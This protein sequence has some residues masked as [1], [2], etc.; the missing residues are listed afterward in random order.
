CNVCQYRWRDEA[1]VPVLLTAVK[2]RSTVEK[3]YQAI[4]MMSADD[5]AEIRTVLRDVAITLDQRLHE[6]F[7]KFRGDI[8]EGE[9]V[10]RCG[11]RLAGVEPT[12]KRNP[13]GGNSQVRGRVNNRRIFA[14]ELEHDRCQVLCRSRHDDLRYR[15]SA[16]EEDVIPLLFQQRGGLGDRAEHNGKRLAVEVF[17]KGARDRFAGRRRNF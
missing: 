5:P 17:R 3:L 12:T 11:A 4:E 9:N 16:S 6:A 13:A 2:N 14:A 10:V 15:G 8:L 1:I 7:E